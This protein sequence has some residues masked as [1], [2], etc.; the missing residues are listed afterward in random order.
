VL[1]WY[2]WDEDE[3]IPNKEEDYATFMKQDLPAPQLPPSS[4]PDAMLLV[5]LSATA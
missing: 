1:K 2:K 3:K 5:L 4:L